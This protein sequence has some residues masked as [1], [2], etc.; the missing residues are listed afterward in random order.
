MKV[1]PTYTANEIRKMVSTFAL[2]YEV[3]KTIVDIVEEEIDLYD[4]EDLIIITQAS[5]I[6]FSRSMLKLSLKNIK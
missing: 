5:L 1:Q 4:E 6:M 2:E 3:F